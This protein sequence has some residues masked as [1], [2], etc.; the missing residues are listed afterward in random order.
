MGTIRDINRLKKNAKMACELFM[1]ECKRRGL[2]V[3]ITETLRTK[4]RQNE[5]YAQGRTAPGKIVTWT[6][7]S[8]HM[9]GLAWDICKNKKGEEY[10]DLKFFEECGMVA[11][12][13]G[14]TWGG[15]W[16]NKDMPHFEVTDDWEGY[17][18]KEI[19][20]IKKELEAIRGEFAKLKESE[21][22]YR[23]TLDVPEWARP[24]VQKL[25]NKGYYKGVADDDLNLPESVMRILV[26]LDR[27]GVFDK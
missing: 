26:I 8:K 22:V 13:L 4:E 11:K 14:I 3:V 24:T 15:T 2:A 23:Y 21:V 20:A 27:A 10:S 7:N 19:E 25:L 5:L 1:E 6:K 18:L 9:T 17:D 12:E 16:K